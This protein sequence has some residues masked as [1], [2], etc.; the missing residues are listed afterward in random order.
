MV[1][2]ATKWVEVAPE[3]VIWGNLNL[4]P[5]EQKVF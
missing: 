5:Y 1:S 3:D 4:N 2:I